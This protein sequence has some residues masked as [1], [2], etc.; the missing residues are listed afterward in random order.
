MKCWCELRE[1]GI[2]KEPVL[3]VASAGSWAGASPFHGR[4]ADS[5]P[6]PRKGKREDETVGS[7]SLL[8]SWTFLRFGGKK[9]NRAAQ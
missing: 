5:R 8:A 2:C 3:L 6:V 7:V 9:S 4:G 1:E